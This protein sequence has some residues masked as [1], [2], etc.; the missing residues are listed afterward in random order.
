MRIFVVSQCFYPEE[1]KINDL[2]EEW[3]QRGHDVTVLTGKPNYPKG[4]YFPGY[5]FWGVQK[6][7]YKGASVIRVPLFKRGKGGA[8]RLVLNYLSFVFFGCWYVLFHKIHAD[9]T[10][11]F[12]LSPIT[13]VYP[14]LLLKLKTKVKVSIWVQDLWPESVSAVGAMQGHGAAWRFLTKMVTG[15]YKKCDTIFIQSPA[16]R[17][18]ICQKGDFGDKIVYAPNWAE[19]LYIE[20]VCNVDK[21]CALMPDGFKIMFAGNIGKAQDF[22]AIINAALLTKGNPYVKWVIVGDGRAR[23]EAEMKV[24]ELGL[25]ETVTFLGRYPAVEMPDFFVHADVLLVSLKRENIFAMTIPSKLQ[26][27]MAFGKPVVS[28]LDGIGNDVIQEADCG[29][30]ASAGDYKALAVN[31]VELSQT[32]KTVL[33]EMARNAKRYYQNHFAKANV[34]DVLTRHLV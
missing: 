33:E 7:T 21:Y 28:M 26:T 22:D 1:F 14:A 4:E 17:E 23:A 29:L 34:V 20:P 5:R 10:F 2:V 19:A 13:Q 31:V 11:C 6:E 25:N 18:S 32:D 30:T 9:A 15:I 24:D 16:F 3:V 8:I 12:A 27:Y